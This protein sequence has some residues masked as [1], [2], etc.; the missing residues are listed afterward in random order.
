MQGQGG[1][2]YGNGNVKVIVE[3]KFAEAD[4]KEFEDRY[5]G[6]KSND[7][8]Q[9][10]RPPGSG[11]F[12]KLRKDEICQEETE[13]EAAE[14]ALERLVADPNTPHPFAYQGGGGVSQNK[15]GEGKES[16]CRGQ[17]ALEGDQAAKEGPAE[18]IGGSGQPGGFTGSQHGTKPLSKK[19]AE[20]LLPKTQDLDGKG[21]GEQRP[22]DDGNH[23][24]LHLQQLGAVENACG[25]DYGQAVQELAIDFLGGEAHGSERVE[26]PRLKKWSG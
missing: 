13:K 3:D 12:G 19:F 11:K 20:G 1:E 6:G 10:K 23:P 7:L 21:N 24:L 9:R 22:D 14:S 8:L 2:S 16:G 4:G 18:N 26:M 25:Q 15:E 5:E 17:A